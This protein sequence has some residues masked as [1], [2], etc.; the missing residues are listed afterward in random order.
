MAASDTAGKHLQTLG[1]GNSLMR[2]KLY[3]T[4]HSS[5]GLKALAGGVSMTSG[6]AWKHAVFRKYW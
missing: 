1:T 6:L 3:Q 2:A 4:A 5:W